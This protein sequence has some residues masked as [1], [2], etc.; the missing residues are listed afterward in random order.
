[1][2]S[3]RNPARDFVAKCRA[4]ASRADT[5]RQH[6]S[7]GERALLSLLP[8][9]TAQYAVGPYIL[10][11]AWPET[12]VALELDGRGHASRR[13]GDVV[14]DRYLRRLGWTVVRVEHDAVL[15]RRT[16][17]VRALGPLR[18]VLEEL[19]PTCTCPIRAQPRE[20]STG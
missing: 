3:E 12:Q 20:V 5:Y 13:A 18:E 14:R 10:D 19:V 16:K 1:M 15:D 8:G 6:L 2:R 17:R 11:F 4:A 7:A 9:T